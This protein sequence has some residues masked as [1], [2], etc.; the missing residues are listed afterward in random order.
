MG[1]PYA[2]DWENIDN[3]TQYSK[4][5]DLFYIDGRTYD[6]RSAVHNGIIGLGADLKRIIKESNNERTDT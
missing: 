6:R 3:R 1:R 2:N 5:L 4:S